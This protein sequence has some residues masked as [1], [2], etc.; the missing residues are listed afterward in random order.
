[1]SDKDKLKKKI[2]KEASKDSGLK[3]VRIEGDGTAKTSEPE[4]VKPK[5]EVVTLQHQPQPTPSAPSQIRQRA[6]AP[7]SV[8]APKFV[9][10]FPRNKI[11]S[12][13]KFRKISYLF[14]SLLFALS[15]FFIFSGKVPL[16]IDFKGG[17]VANVKSTRTEQVKIDDLR[18]VFPGVFVQD[19]GDGN[20]LLRL[21]LSFVEEAKALGKD[22][23]SL[24]S[25][26]LKKVGE[27]QILK[28]ESVGSVSGKELRKSG[29]Y[30]FI[31]S[32]IGIFLY[33]VFRFE[34]KFAVGAIVGVVHDIVV[35]IGLMSL[36][37]VELS[38]VTLGGLLALAGYSVND[39]IIIS[40]R[41]R[42]K[43]QIMRGVLNED[44]INKAI[45][46]TLPRTI[47]TVLTILIPV[48]CLIFLGGE[49]LKGI[50]TVFLFGSIFGTY[51]SIFIVAALA[52]DINLLMKKRI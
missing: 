48:F 8:E 5:P 32:F 35:T 7:P 38:L 50:G 40:D 52:Y 30:A 39:S 19:F 49:V 27:F 37:D 16:G 23:S 44:V 18:A 47:L 46:E 3:G 15:L 21:P 11:I 17:V 14:S 26:N 6:V 36:F 4:L 10:F 43:V 42:E 33:I 28:V 31:L 1:M 29:V 51:S 12:F 22:A 9:S 24:L 34:W 2:Y 20:F 41:I 13:M 25:E 45:S